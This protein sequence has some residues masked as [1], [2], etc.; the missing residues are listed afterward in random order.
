VEKE[1][2]AE[3]LRVYARWMWGLLTEPV[4]PYEYVPLATNFV[5]RLEALAKVDV[6][7]IDMAGA[8]DRARQFHGLATQLDQAAKDWGKRAAADGE[9]AADII[10]A[11]MLRVSRILVPVASTVVGA[12]GQDRYGHAWQTSM[13]PSLTPY[14]RLATFAADSEEMQTWWVA[15]IRARNQVV[16]A[17]DDAIATVNAGLTALN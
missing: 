4:L 6:A 1:R 16:D 9:Q 3:H 14:P 17:L 13:I 10:N 2:L 7:K 12:Y 8:L 15:M 5:E 11:T